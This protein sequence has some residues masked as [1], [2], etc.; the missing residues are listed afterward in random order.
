MKKIVLLLTTALFTFASPQSVDSDTSSV[1]FEVTKMFFIDV[2]GSF[3]KFSGTIEVEHGNLIAVNGVIQATS[4][5]TEN[6]ERD[7]NLNTEGFFNTNKYP[8][9]IFASTKIEGTTLYADVTV[10]GITQNLAFKINHFSSDIAGSQLQLSSDVDRQDF[11]VNGT[12]GFAITDIA[13]VT[14]TLNSK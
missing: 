9:I 6:E 10:K 11:G 4:V 3:E 14:A 1:N 5:H 2:Q 7:T 13:H 12:M 8:S